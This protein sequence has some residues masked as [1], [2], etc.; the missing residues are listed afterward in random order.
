MTA[1]VRRALTDSEP[2]L[3]SLPD[4]VV[5]LLLAVSAPPR[6]AAHLRAVHDVAAQLADWF[7]ATYPAVPFDRSAVL[8]GAATHDIGKAVH[9]QELSGPGTEHEPEGYHLLLAYG[10]PEHLA[11]FARDHGSW[12]EP[13]VER[14]LVTL[15]DKVWKGKR[16]PGLEQSFVDFLGAWTGEEPWRTFMA[17]DDV[18]TRIA[19]QAD[20]RLAYQNRYS[21]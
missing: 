3:R 20:A 1:E 15:A 10:V 4:H 2:R 16:E 17:L 18:L 11:R 9:R 19:G 5:D 6:L 12:T 8:F 14:L 13:T 21:T 7:A